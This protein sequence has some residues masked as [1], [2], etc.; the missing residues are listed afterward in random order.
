[1]D[2][3]AI[4]GVIGLRRSIV[5]PEISTLPKGKMTTSILGM[6]FASVSD[7]EGS[8][9]ARFEI[10]SDRG[11]NPLDLKPP[12][13]E[14]VKPLKMKADEFEKR[15]ERL[16]GFQRVVSSINVDSETMATLDKAILK[17]VNVKP[18]GSD[19]PW[20]ESFSLRLVGLLPASTD[21][22]YIEV[23]GKKHNGS[24]SFTVCS[25]NALATNSILDTLKKALKK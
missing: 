15:M 20:L 23:R 24:G 25:D 22:L 11:N 7:K 17:Q 9:H 13:G 2:R 21:K 3:K 1:L 4:P 5:P 16:Q 10:K 19:K 6:D 12:L 18:L 8:L 14:L